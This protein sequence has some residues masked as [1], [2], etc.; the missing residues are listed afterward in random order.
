MD[1]GRRI[2]STSDDKSIRVWDWN[3]PVDT[4]HIAEPGMHSLAS[5]AMHPNKKWLIFQSLDNTIV[6]YGTSDKFR[7]N[8]KKTFKGHLVSAYSCQGLFIFIF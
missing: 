5:V 2:V 1:E 4:K 8:P 7:K 3:V 6:T